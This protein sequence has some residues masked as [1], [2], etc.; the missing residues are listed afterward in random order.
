MI[1]TN[2]IWK[3]NYSEVL[4]CHVRIEKNKFNNYLRPF[5]TSKWRTSDIPVE[6]FSIP[7]LQKINATN[8]ACIWQS[9]NKIKT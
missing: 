2:K 4:S 9:H 1:N 8:F 3:N 5:R 7:L 6:F